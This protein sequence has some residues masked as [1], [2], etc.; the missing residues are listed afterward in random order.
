MVSRMRPSG[1][2]VK[3]GR[4]VPAAGEA[5]VERVDGGAGETFGFGPHFGQ[6]AYDRLVEL[7]LFP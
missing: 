6:V 3:S 1:E 2:A 5:R 4:L 7:L